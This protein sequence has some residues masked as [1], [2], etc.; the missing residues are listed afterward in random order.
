MAGFFSVEK[1]EESKKCLICEC[2]KSEGIHLLNY[3][4]CEQC[5]YDIVHT[6]VNEKGYRY[7]LD[8]LKKIRSERLEMNKNKAQ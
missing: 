1:Q 3:F 4:I 8:R 7:Y 6:E 2:E 5:E